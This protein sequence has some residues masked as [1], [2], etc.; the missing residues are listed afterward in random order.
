MVV[1]Q[2]YVRREKKTSGSHELHSWPSSISDGARRTL[3][4]DRVD[5]QRV[6][7]LQCDASRGEGQGFFFLKC[8]LLHFEGGSLQP[9]LH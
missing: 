9:P 6:K 7:F 2:E 3:G 4:K 5:I 8:L 1:N